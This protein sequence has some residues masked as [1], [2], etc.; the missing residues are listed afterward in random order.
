MD[1]RLFEQDLG[2]R[3]TKAHQIDRA[4]NDGNYEPG[5]CRWVTKL[6]QMSHTRH[7]HNLEFNGKVLHICEWARQLGVPTSLIKRRLD[8][9]WNVNDIL[10]K[11]AKAKRFTPEEIALIRESTIGCTKLAMAYDVSK[12]TISKIKLGRIYRHVSK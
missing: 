8:R 7:N 2:P 11:P 12:A 10:S 1:F 6:E 9:G 4:D 5:N 3:P